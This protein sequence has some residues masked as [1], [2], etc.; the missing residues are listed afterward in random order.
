[1]AERLH[2][3]TEKSL[4]LWASSLS[5]YIYLS[6]CVSTY[7]LSTC[8]SLSLSL[9]IYLP[10]YLPMYLPIRIY[11]SVYLY[12]CFLL[13]IYLSIYLTT[14]LSAY[15]PIYLCIYLSIYLPDFLSIYPSICLTIIVSIY[16][17]SSLA[18]HPPM[19]LSR[20][21]SSEGSSL[22]SFS[23]IR[24]QM[25]FTAYLQDSAFEVQSSQQN[26]NMSGKNVNGWFASNSGKRS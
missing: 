14:F 22:N 15:L 18:I 9:S 16:L 17:T 1:M 23:R 4:R 8:P 26:S 5:L 10:T 12:D 13:S 7:L 19:Y 3:W 25:A 21:L 6:I 24:G 2:L 11:R 20:H